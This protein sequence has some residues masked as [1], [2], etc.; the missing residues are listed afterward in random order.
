MYTLFMAVNVVTLLIQNSCLT[1]LIFKPVL[2][3]SLD[4]SL[5]NKWSFVHTSW[6]ASPI[7]GEV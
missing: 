3:V 2:D 1:F 6:N 4:I 7:W 5:K